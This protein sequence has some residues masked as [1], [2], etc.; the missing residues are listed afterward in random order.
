MGPDITSVLG[1]IPFVGPIFHGSLVIVVLRLVGLVVAIALSVYLLKRLMGGAFSSGPSERMLRKQ[2][3]YEELGD[4][5]TRRGEHAAAL[6]YFEEAEV[7]V[8]AGHAARRLGNQVEAAQFFDKG[9]ARKLAQAAYEAA[10][11]G[12]DG[13]PKK[14]RPTKS[15]RRSQRPSARSQPKARRS[16]PAAPR[17]QVR[18]PSAA[19]SQ[20]DGRSARMG[21]GQIPRPQPSPKPIRTEADSMQSEPI[22]PSGTGNFVQLDEGEEAPRPRRK[23]PSLGVDAPF[24]SASVFDPRDSEPPAA[25]RQD[26]YSDVFELES[27][28]DSVEAFIGS[29]SAFPTPSKPIRQ[30]IEKTGLTDIGFAE[31]MSPS[32]PDSPMDITPTELERLAWDEGQTEEQKRKVAP[33][34]SLDTNDPRTSLEVPPPSRRRKRQRSEFPK[35]SFGRAVTDRYEIQAA[36]G[37]GGMAEVFE[38]VDATLGRLVALK[39]LSPAMMGNDYA[40]KYF[41]REARAAA[42]LNHPSIVTIYDVGVLDERPFISM[43]YIDGSDVA[44]RLDE[45]GP[46]PMHFAIDVAI[47]VAKA[48]DYAHE[49]NVV[50]RDIKPANVMLVSGGGV[51]ILDFGLAKAIQA[52]TRGQSI[53]AGTP[54]YMAPEQLAGAEIDGRTDIFAFGVTFYELLTREVPFEGALRRHGVEPPSVYDNSIPSDIDEI[55]LKCIE[56]DKADRFQTAGDIAKKLKRH[57]VIMER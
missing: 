7:W 55:V 25:P 29:K 53:V 34:V 17:A 51:K 46:L 10:G 48:L 6:K 16:S 42:A 1:D 18:Q 12:P 44:T 15:K 40:M 35:T 28:L 13:R 20:P 27:P 52:D 30:Y 24:A 22:P 57:P 9:G 8:K 2:G 49:R 5:C 23:R 39:F 54:E 56:L 41:Q 4:I 14:T 38:A 32:K 45:E 43:E 21:S 19:P 26:R 31:T 37:E 3:R 33:T 50:H 11:L 47:Q 36:L